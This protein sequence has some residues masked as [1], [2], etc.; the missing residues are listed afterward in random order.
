VI[1]S[2]LL[3]LILGAVLL[4]YI[5][6][7]VKFGLAKSLLVAAGMVVG[8]AIAVLVSSVIVEA[9][10]T[11]DLRISAAA[12]SGVGL[13]ILGSSIGHTIG[14]LVTTRFRTPRRRKRR[15]AAEHF[16]GALVLG[17]SVL[18]LIS[19]MGFGIGNFGS[20]AVSRTFAG[21]VMINTVHKLMPESEEALIF[22]TLSLISKPKG[23]VVIEDFGSPIVET[24]KV[25]AGNVSFAKVLKSVVR[26]TGNGYECGQGMTGT[27]FV[28]ATDRILTNASVVAGV[29]RPVVEEPDGQVLVGRVVFFDADAN[30]AII[31]L[32]GLNAEPLKEGIMATAGETTVIV[33]HPLGGP[34]AITSA[35]V[36]SVRTFNSPNIYGS[37]G[38]PRELYTLSSKME[39]GDSGA[40][41]LTRDG[42]FVGI[43]FARAK[44]QE[45]VAYA[46]TLTELRP[47]IEKVSALTKTVS[48]GVCIRG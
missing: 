1:Y 20:P 32:E 28:I 2:L 29:K 18:M 26:I 40:P 44:D 47:A 17:L 13:V 38:S 4:G 46:M 6:Y 12:A 10:A 27:G 21:S 19:V 9:I 36:Q 41:V 14:H 8:V 31:A 7:G 11:P 35:R 22:Q 34:A 25:V 42:D 45:H 24:P 48:S 23:Q 39:S 3:D 5:S 33:A 15:R 30:I 16:A 37:G 43:V